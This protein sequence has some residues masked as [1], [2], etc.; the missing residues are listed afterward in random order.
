MSVVRWPGPTL[1]TR[2]R[3]VAALALAT[4]G[5]ARLGLGHRGTLGGGRAA[6]AEGRPDLAGQTLPTPPPGP[7]RRASPS[8]TWTAA[9]VSS[10]LPTASLWPRS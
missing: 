10:G 1:S 8:S 9:V 7:W 6:E 3:G 5:H 4:A 2:W